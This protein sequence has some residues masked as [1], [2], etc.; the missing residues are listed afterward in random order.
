MGLAP[1]LHPPSALA[2]AEVRKVLGLMIPPPLAGLLAGLA[3]FGFAAVM[4][5]F[6]VSVIREEKRAATAALASLQL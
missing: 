1:C 3:A 2:I 5:V 6:P 4:L